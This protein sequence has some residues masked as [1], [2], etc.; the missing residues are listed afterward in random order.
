MNQI[1]SYG[2]FTR[3]LTTVLGL[4][5]G[6]T[7]AS[8]QQSHWKTLLKSCLR[9]SKIQNPRSIWS[10]CAL[11][12]YLLSLLPCFL[13]SS[14]LKFGQ[15]RFYILQNF[16]EKQVPNSFETDINKNPH[17]STLCFL[18]CSLNVDMVGT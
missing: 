1:L 13:Y 17:G 16:S 8:S 3:V 4:S 12:V 5:L 9:E 18:D 6:Q 7:E 2:A 14:T 10:E 11:S 15:I